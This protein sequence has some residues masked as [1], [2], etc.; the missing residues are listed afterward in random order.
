MYLQGTGQPELAAGVL[1]YA[2]KRFEIESRSIELSKAADTYNMTYA[3]KGP[4]AGY[5]P[6]AGDGTPDVLWAEG[7]GEMRLAEAALGQ[8]TKDSTR[9]SPNG[10]PPPRVRP[11]A[12]RQDRHRR[13]ARILYHVWP[14]STAAAWTMLAQ[15]P[16]AFFS[17][18]IPPEALTNWAKI[19][20]GNLTTIYPDGR[21]DMTGAGERRV[22]APGTAANYTT[23]SKVT[24]VSGAGYGIYVR[25][26]TDATLKL[27]AYCVQL[28][29]A[30]GTGQIVVREILNDVELGVPIAH[31]SVPAGFAWYGV[32]HALGVTVQGNTMK[33]G[34]D[35]SQLISVPDLATA[36]RAAV[37]YAYGSSSTLTPPTAGGYGLRSWGDGLSSSSR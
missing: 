10:R 11:A 29:H 2:Q 26:T 1:A 20:G 7:S 12:V 9:A 8:D 35:G 21:V 17:A 25:G 18:P 6:Y 36:S 19:R 16:S 14:A 33:V 24:L 15:T 13:A 37:T 28:D 32:A 27:T 22:L 3:A 23:T 34:L 4:F 30:Y 31:V 5:A